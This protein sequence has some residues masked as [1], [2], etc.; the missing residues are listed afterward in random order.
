ML[1]KH[2]GFLTDFWCYCYLPRTLILFER[3]FSMRHRRADMDMQTWLGTWRWEW[4]ELAKLYKKWCHNCNWTCKQGDHAVMQPW[5]FGH[6]DVACKH[7]D[8]DMQTW[9]CR[10]GHWITWLGTCR[11][12]WQAFIWFWLVFGFENYFSMI[13]VG[14]LICK[15]IFQDFHWFIDFNVSLPWQFKFFQEKNSRQNQD[16]A[17]SW[18]SQFLNWKTF[19]IQSLTGKNHQ[20][21]DHARNW[22]NS[23]FLNC[24]VYRHF[25]AGKEPIWAIPGSIFLKTGQ[26]LSHLTEIWRKSSFSKPNTW[27]RSL[28]LLGYVFQILGVCLLLGR[29]AGWN[30]DIL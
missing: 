23:K 11:W 26:I 30:V 6:A 29:C 9:I 8:M 17:K 4:Q 15:F 28:V 12:E 24:P 1:E 20:N 2:P 10:H 18:K 22:K 27:L 3:D 25:E 5:R 13:L 21:Q 14:F 19:Q 16:S 7:S